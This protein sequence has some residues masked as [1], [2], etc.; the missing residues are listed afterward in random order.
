[1]SNNIPPLSTPVIYWR[2][3]RTLYDLLN[4][5]EYL[6]AGPSQAP[7]RTRISGYTFATPDGKFSIGPFY[8]QTRN[9]PGYWFA[10]VETEMAATPSSTPN[11]IYG[12]IVS[13]YER[14]DNVQYSDEQTVLPSYYI[15]ISED[16]EII[17][18][19]SFKFNLIKQDFSGNNAA[20]INWMPPK[21][22]P[23]NHYEQYQMGL[24]GSTPNVVATP[25]YIV[26]Y[27]E[28]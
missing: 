19:P 6:G 7:E 13:W 25:N 21:W 20:S 11:V 17:A 15:S 8:S 1:M 26:G 12:D 4:K 16:K 14:F 18:T 24:F 3:A 28:S 27:E 22:M 10:S 2:K 23:I 5:V 9:N